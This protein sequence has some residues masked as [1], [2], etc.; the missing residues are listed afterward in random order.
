MVVLMIKEDDNGI[1]FSIE[2]LLGLNSYYYPYFNC[3]KYKFDYTD[4]YLEK[5]YFQKA[6]DTAELMATVTGHDD[7]TI[8][9]EV[10]QCTFRKSR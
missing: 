7:Q 5:K 2:A 1:F 3:C 4:S 6:Q 9:E 10:S 8:L